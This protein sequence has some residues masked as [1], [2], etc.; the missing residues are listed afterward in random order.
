ME[1]VKS[2]ELKV[3]EA[4]R[5]FDVPPTTLKDR[6]SGRGR[7]GRNPGPEPYLTS[8]EENCLAEF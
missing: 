7:H 8:N 1:A 5:E 3:N 4:A 6:I 2:G